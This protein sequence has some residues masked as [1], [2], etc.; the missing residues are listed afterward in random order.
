MA[1]AFSHIVVATVMGKLYTNS[2][3]PVRFWVATIVCSVLP[4]LDVIGFY[5]GIEYGDFLGHRGFSHSLVFAFIVGLLVTMF[6]FKKPRKFSLGWWELTVYFSL[7]TASHG[8]LDALT[9]GGLGIA[10]FSPFDMT[11]YFF[12]WNP[13]RVSPIGVGAF[14]S[15]WGFEV[16]KSEIV[17]IWLP[18]ILGLGI[19]KGIRRIL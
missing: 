15:E 19:V 11:R 4:D 3:M 16:I 13:V 1:S 14:F 7:I 17:W 5:F 6:L 18:T 9:N 10:F 12:P 2:K 8:V